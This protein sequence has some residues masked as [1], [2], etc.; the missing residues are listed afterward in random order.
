MIKK[1]KDIISGPEEEK[2]VVILDP[3]SLGPQ[4]PDMRVVGL[5]ADV[6]ANPRLDRL[7]RRFVSGGGDA[8][9]AGFLWHVPIADR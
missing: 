2:K 4:E 9:R 6:P 8:T 5:F 3:A 7:V 1:I